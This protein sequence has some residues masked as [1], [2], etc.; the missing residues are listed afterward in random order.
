MIDP[1][2]LTWRSP[3]SPPTLGE[4]EI[5]L[6]LIPCAS[7]DDNLD[8]GQQQAADGGS[9]PQSLWSILSTAEQDRASRFR[10]SRHRQAYVRAHAGLRLILAGYLDQPPPLIRFDLGPQGKPRVGGPWEFNLT[11]SGGLALVAIRL[12]YPVG[13]DCEPIRAD[14]DMLA[15]ARRLFSPGEIEQ[16]LSCPASDRPWLFTRFWTALE[17]RVKMDGYGL[18]HRPSAPSTPPP[19]IVHFSPRAGYLAAIAS[20]RIPPPILWQTLRLSLDEMPLG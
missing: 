10:L 18:F 8:P 16:L 20:P 5:H 9:S 15:I 6:W 19:G 3:P 11:T 7:G 4:E 17:A 12:A 2:P 14:R 13:I 1:P